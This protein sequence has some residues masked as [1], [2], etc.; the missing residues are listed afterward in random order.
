MPYADLPVTRAMQPL[1]LKE[2][3]ATG[4][5]VVARSLP[6]LQEWA[7]CVDLATGP[8]NSSKPSSD[9]S[10]SGLP[11]DQKVAR[12]RLASE[13]WEAKAE[14]FERWLLPESHA[15]IPTGAAQP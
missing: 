15:P 1:K 3:L 11:R 10:Q 12:E 9:G 6:A 5:P 14:Q 8:R 7:D 2:Y 4:K 13:S